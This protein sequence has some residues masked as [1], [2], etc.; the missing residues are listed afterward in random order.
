MNQNQKNKKENNLKQERRKEIIEELNKKYVGYSDYVNSNESLGVYIVRDILKK[1]NTKG[2]WIDIVE[3]NNNNPNNYDGKY[4]PNLYIVFRLYKRV[5]KPIYPPKPKKDD[6]Y[7]LEHWQMEVDAIT[8]K[9]AHND[10]NYWKSKGNTGYKKTLVCYYEKYSFQ[11]NNKNTEIKIKKIKNL[12]DEQFNNV[13]NMYR[14]TNI[15]N[16]LGLD[17][18]KS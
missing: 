18:R 4:S 6:A 17:L 14:L 12:S 7:L 13:I 15:L 5:T 16:Y 11:N 2:Y 3:H 1:I 8:W 10:I 9:T